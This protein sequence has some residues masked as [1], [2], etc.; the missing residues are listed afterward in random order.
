[1]D[2]W[3][4]LF[5]PKHSTIMVE[6]ITKRISPEVLEATIKIAKVTTLKSFHLALIAKKPIIHIISVGGSQM[7]DVTNAVSYGTSKRYAKPNSNKEKLRLTKINR[8][9]SSCLRYHALP[10]TAPQ[11]VGL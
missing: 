4:V 1:M 7:Q 10:P 2:P 9:R 8:K 5:K 3:K 6:K 11:K